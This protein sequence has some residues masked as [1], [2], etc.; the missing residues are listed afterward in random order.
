MYAGII[1][2]NG[3]NNTMLGVAPWANLYILKAID[4]T[5]SGKVSWVVNAINYAS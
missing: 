1:A 5:G 4:R 2:A 3:N